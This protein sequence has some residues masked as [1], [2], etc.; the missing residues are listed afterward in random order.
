MR[1]PCDIVGVLRAMSQERLF[2]PNCEGP[3]DVKQVEASMAPMFSEPNTLD[4]F[5]V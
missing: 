3:E 2:G 4:K 5:R 1:F